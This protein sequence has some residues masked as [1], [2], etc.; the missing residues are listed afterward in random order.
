[1]FHCAV[2][3]LGVAG[4]YELIVIALGS[5]Y[6]GNTLV[7]ENPIVHV[8]AHHVRIHTLSVVVTVAPVNSPEPEE[9]PPA[10]VIR[11]KPLRSGPRNS[12]Q[13]QQQQ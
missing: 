2:N 6:A 10:T 12:Y 5:E 1:M 7:G 8:V 11:S 9:L 13:D 3:V 4:K